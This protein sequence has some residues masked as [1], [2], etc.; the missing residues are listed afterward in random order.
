MQKEN[1]LFWYVIYAQPIPESP[2]QPIPESPQ[3]PNQEVDEAIEIE[4]PEVD[5]NDAMNALVMAPYVEADEGY[6]SDGSRK[7]K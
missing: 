5:M 3:Q 4:E 7:R 1:R 2:Q 6:F